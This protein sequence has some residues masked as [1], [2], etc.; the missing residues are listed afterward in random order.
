MLFFVC[1]FFL[2]LTSSAS[3]CVISGTFFYSSQKSQNCVEKKNHPKISVAF[4][5]FCEL[6]LFLTELHRKGENPKL[7]IPGHDFYAE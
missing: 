7:Y 3:I 2:F 4:C 5:A 1:G 6:F